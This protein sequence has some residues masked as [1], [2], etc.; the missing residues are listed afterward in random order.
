[1]HLLRKLCSEYEQSCACSPRAAC[2]LVQIAR[3]CQVSIL[4]V[5]QVDRVQSIWY[6]RI[7]ILPVCAAVSESRRNALQYK[8]ADAP[9]GRLSRMLCTLAILIPAT[10]G[11]PPPCPWSLPRPQPRLCHGHSL[12]PLFLQALARHSR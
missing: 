8:K 7:D 10:P 5:V 12:L 11:P 2:L 4:H 1:M 6:D 3:S 9:P